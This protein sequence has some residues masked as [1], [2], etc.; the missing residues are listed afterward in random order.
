MAQFSKDDVKILYT[1]SDDP[2]ALIE[3]MIIPDNEIF[4]L[5]ENSLL[6]DNCCAYLDFQLYIL[7][8]M[9]HAGIHILNF[10]TEVLATKYRSIIKELS[11]QISHSKRTNSSDLPLISSRHHIWEKL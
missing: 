3:A 9:N 1:D 7:D 2:D 5:I 10:K 11:K 6:N 4:L 8:L